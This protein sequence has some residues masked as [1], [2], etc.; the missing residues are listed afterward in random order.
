[1]SKGENEILRRILARYLKPEIKNID[2]SHMR[3]ASDL[4]KVSY[5]ILRSPDYSEKNFTL[6]LFD[7]RYRNPYSLLIDEYLVFFSFKSNYN[8]I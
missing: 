1:M 8:S 6:L 5:K 4:K 2:I 3:A 7:P